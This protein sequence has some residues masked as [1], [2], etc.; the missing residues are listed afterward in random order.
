MSVDVPKENKDSVEPSWID[1]D[2]LK[3]DCVLLILRSVSL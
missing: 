3:G 2:K 1:Y